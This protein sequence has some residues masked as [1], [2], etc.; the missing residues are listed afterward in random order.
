MRARTPGAEMSTSSEHGELS[1]PLID[2]N[3]DNGGAGG[4]A[5]ETSSSSLPTSSSSSS[6]RSSHHHP[7]P[8]IPTKAEADVPTVDGV[9]FTAE[10]A[11]RELGGATWPDGGEEEEGSL[12]STQHGEGGGGGLSWHSVSAFM[13]SIILGLGVL[14]IPEAFA[15]LGWILGFVIMAVVAVGAVYSGVAIADVTTAAAAVTGKRPR[16]Y[17]ALGRAAFG[18]R[19]H[20]VV[21]IVQVSSTAYTRMRCNERGGEGKREEGGIGRG[22][23]EDA[24]RGPEGKTWEGAREGADLLGND[25]KNLLFCVC[26][27]VCMFVCVRMCVRTRACCKLSACLTDCYP[28]S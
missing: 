6:S 21:R 11:A 10:D 9:F 15:Q 19:G 27:C 14:G 17:P 26:F 25:R 7:L 24:T 28:E 22:S 1:A 8:P 13:V 16:S 2:R 5:P 23:S 12:S 3:S 18:Q 20:V 4:E